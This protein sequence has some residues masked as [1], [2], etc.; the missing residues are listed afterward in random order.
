MHFEIGHIYHIFNQGNNR[1]RIFF[2]RDNYIFFLEK[3][4]TYVLPFGDILAYCLMPNHFHLMVYVQATSRSTPRDENLYYS[5]ILSPST[6]ADDG[7]EVLSRSTTDSINS[8]K[9]SVISRTTTFNKSIGIMLTSYTRAINIQ[10]YR[11]GSLFKPHTKAECLTQVEDVSP[12][13]FNTAN[14]AMINIPNPEKEYPKVCFNYIH[15]NPVKAG[16]VNNPG[17][18][19]FSSYQSYY[20]SGDLRLINTAK[21]REFGLL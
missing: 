21:A 7:D 9:N 15:N 19:E 17:D 16:L 1:Q 4:E 3:I 18:W 11:S 5:G 13:F 6:T 8:N 14:G 10:E 20:G 12:S 2:K